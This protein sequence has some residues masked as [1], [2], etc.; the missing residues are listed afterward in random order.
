MLGPSVLDVPFELHAQYHKHIPSFALDI[1]NT[2]TSN[3]KLQITAADQTPKTQII[4][5]R[6]G[7]FF[8]QS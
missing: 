7:Q 1:F 4:E 5:V 6:T 2:N 8:R 3:P